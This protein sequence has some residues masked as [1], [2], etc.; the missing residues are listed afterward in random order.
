[1]GFILKFLE[2]INSFPKLKNISK[3]ILACCIGPPGM[4]GFPGKNSRD[5][6]DGE[7]GEINKGNIINSHIKN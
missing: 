6:Y 2:N 3:I 7:P 5:G 1:M 4:K